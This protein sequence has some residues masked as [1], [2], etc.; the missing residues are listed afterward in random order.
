MNV[1]VKWLLAVLVVG[2]LAFS[3]GRF[4][5]PLKVEEKWQTETVYKDRIVEKR[6]E[7]AGKTVTKVV[8]LDRVIKPDGTVH[9][10][11]ETREA[12]KEDITK[13]A[14]RSSES[15]ATDKATAEK[16]ST[17][18]PQWRVG[19]LAGASV[20]APLLPIAGP[21]SVGVHAER[22]IVGGV[23]AGVWVLTSGQAGASVSVEF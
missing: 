9:E 23:S 4:S 10:K 15:N 2:V 6:V 16:K 11:S 20:T 14:G 22:R 13:I 3:G 1:H 5:A 7:V 17:L 8:Y 21:L 12:T 18:Q 19:V